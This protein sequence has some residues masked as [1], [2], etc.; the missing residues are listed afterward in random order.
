MLYVDL[1]AL[2]LDPTTGS[3]QGTLSAFG[4]DLATDDH[5]QRPERQAWLSDRCS[6]RAGRETLPGTFNYSPS[7]RMP[8]LSAGWQAAGGGE[9]H[10]AG[11]YSSVWLRPGEC[12]VLEEVLPRRRHE[13]SRLGTL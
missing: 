10:P 7:R 6:R 5:R 4:F 3:Q 13:P 9:S 2:G 1:I 11:Q 12:A 8:A